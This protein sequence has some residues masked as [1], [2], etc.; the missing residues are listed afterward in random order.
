MQPHEQEDFLRYYWQE[1][2]FLRRMGEDFARRHP[3]VAGRLELQTDQ[4][5]DPH[6]ERLIEAFA[7]LTARIQRNIDND[8]PELA[9]ELLEVVHPHY[10]RP[11]PSMAIARFDGDPEQGGLGSGYQL[12]RHTQIYTHSSAGDTCRFRTAYPVDLWP[13]KVADAG[14]ESAD[15]YDFL[16][17]TSAVTSVLRLRIECTEES[18]VETAMERL[19]FFLHGDRLLISSLYE[20][21]FAQVIKVAVLPDRSRTPRYLSADRIQPV[22]FG[23]EEGVL[24]YPRYSQS[25]YRL[26]Q[27]YFVFPEK[28]YFFDL[29]GLENLGADQY[30]DLLFLLERAPSARLSVN[31]S[32]FQLGCTPI[33]NLFSKHTEPIRVD[34]RGSQYRLVADY[35]REKTTEIFSVSKVLGTTGGDKESK[36]Y[37]PF[38]SFDHHMETQDHRT[39]WHGQRVPSLRSDVEGTDIMLSFV[40]LDFKPSVPPTESVHA[41]TLCTNRALPEQIPAQGIFYTEEV[42]PLKSILCLS[43]PSRTLPPP[44]SG[45]NL[46]RL[47]SHLSLNY[48]SLTDGEESLKAL[49]EILKLY[50]F[51]DEAAVQQQVLGIREMT[52]RKVVRRL[53]IEAW[54]GFCRGTEVTLTFDENYYVGTNAFLLGA[55]L[56]R[57]FALYSSTNHFTQLVI[58]SEQREGEWKRWLPTAGEMIVL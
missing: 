23:L 28:F 52:Q 27:E 29:D 39:Y 45:Q 35:R 7:F 33:V 51:V 44:L 43:K 22:G 48:L 34:Q 13:V 2:T 54:R 30:F 40:D 49:R 4:S 26:I 14:F 9:S 11:V 50:S 20:M 12:R 31:R 42:A 3:K 1:L 15:Q 8:F 41:E 38:Y 10:I 46:W 57:F 25:A 5:P 47:I 36:T 53:G 55:V 16:D 18:L 58:R 37:L 6:V 17:T 56:N 21:L 19:R 24:P 32:T